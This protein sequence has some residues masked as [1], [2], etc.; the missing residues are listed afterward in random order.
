MVVITPPDW[1]RP[2]PFC[3]GNMHSMIVGGC[4]GIELTSQRGHLVRVLEGYAC[5]LP[6]QAGATSEWRNRYTR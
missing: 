6:G 5:W 3:K 4:D 1:T 2:P